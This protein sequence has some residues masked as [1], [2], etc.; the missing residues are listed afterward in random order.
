M[1]TVTMS[2]LAF[3]PAA[4]T[5]SPGSMVTW[6]NKEDAPHTIASKGGGALK[7]KNLQKGDSYT[8][9]FSTA[10]TFSYYCTIHPNMTGKVAVQ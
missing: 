10:G 4:V 7:S 2:G 9:T 3:S 8:Y 5:V 6:T 1:S